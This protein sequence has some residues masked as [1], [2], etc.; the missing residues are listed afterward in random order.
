MKKN[1]TAFYKTF[2]VVLAITV[3]V[4][5]ILFIVGEKTWGLGFILGNLTTLFLMSMLNRSSYRVV[6][7]QT[8]EQAKGIAMR[9]YFFRYFFY[10]L[11]LVVAG[12]HDGFNLLATGL[13]L[14]VFKLVLYIIGYLEGRGENND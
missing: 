13:G 6:E 7:S 8:P 3:L 12:Y 10:A 14:F 9:S 11:I 5:A 4:G 1:D 2:P